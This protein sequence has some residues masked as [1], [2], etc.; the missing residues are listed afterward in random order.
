MRTE[1]ED[2]VSLVETSV[3]TNLLRLERMRSASLQASMADAR[4]SLARDMKVAA[5]TLENVRKGRLKGV[6]LWVAEKI[7]GALI[8]ELEREMARLTHEYQILVQCGAHRVDDEVSEVESLL[9]RARQ[10]LEAMK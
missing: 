7:H 10:A 8:R 6:R 2:K 5:G 4:K 1:S 9:A 3:R